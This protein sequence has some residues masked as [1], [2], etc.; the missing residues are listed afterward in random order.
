MPGRSFM[1]SYNGCEMA[2]GRVAQHRV[3]PPF[4]F[5]REYGDT[6]V[7]AGV[8]LD[9]RPSSIERHPDTWKPPMATGIPASRKRSR[10]VEGTGILVRLDADERDKTEISVT[11]KAGDEPLD[12]HA[13]VG[14]VHHL[15]VDGNVRSQ[16]LPLGAIGRNAVHGRERVRRNHRTPPADHVAVV[17]VMRRLDQDELEASPSRHAHPRMWHFPLDAWTPYHGPTPKDTCAEDHTVRASAWASGLNAGVYVG[18]SK[19]HPA[20][21][22]GRLASGVMRSAVMRLRLLSQHAEAEAVEGEALPRL[23]DRARLVDDEAGDGGRLVRP[24]GSS[25]SRG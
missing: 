1:K 8:E 15:D 19:N 18:I 7:P 23:R 20:R 14:L 10:D 21:A 4:G 13:R 24:A 12:V 6:H 5:T 3:E 11:S 22:T 2:V 16:D 17:V 25:P 9:A